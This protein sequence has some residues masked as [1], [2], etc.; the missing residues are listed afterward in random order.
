MLTFAGLIS[1][2]AEIQFC[3]VVGVKVA[4]LE[5]R[6]CWKGSKTLGK[7]KQPLC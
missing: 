6:G 5:A 1:K 7:V 4:F 2:M 3:C